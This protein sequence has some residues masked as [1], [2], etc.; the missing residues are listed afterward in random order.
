MKNLSPRGSSINAEAH[1]I[2]RKPASKHFR[3]EVVVTK[4][5]SER[6]VFLSALVAAALFM[7]AFLLWS[8]WTSIGDPVAHQGDLG[9]PSADSAPEAP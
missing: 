7:V 6:R 8:H 3:W 4:A 5:P 9:F 2:S 1:K